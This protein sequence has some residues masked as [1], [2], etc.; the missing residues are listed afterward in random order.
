MFIRVCP[1]VVRIRRIHLE[2]PLD[3]QKYKRCVVFPDGNETA[4][5]SRRNDDRPFPASPD[6]VTFE[7]R[8]PRYRVSANRFSARLS[9]AR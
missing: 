1:D 4:I 9:R 6:P 7:E 8:E 2:I 5:D 3:T